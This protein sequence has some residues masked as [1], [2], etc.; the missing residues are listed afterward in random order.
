[1]T[2]S[3]SLQIFRF[4]GAAW[5]VAQIEDGVRTVVRALKRKP[6]DTGAFQ[7]LLE[8]EHGVSRFQARGG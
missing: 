6:G 3:E 5:E 4:P 2:E 7:P 8:F 1:M